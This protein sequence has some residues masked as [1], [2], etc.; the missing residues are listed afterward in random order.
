M[1]L[2]PA[3]CLAALLGV[4][5]APAAATAQTSSS[6]GGDVG[7][8]CWEKLPTVGFIACFDSASVLNTFGFLP[9]GSLGIPGFYQV[10]S[11]WCRVNGQFRWVS[12]DEALSCHRHLLEACFGTPAC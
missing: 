1:R 2:L 3:L 8:P 11:S 12:P 7:C 6:S 10:I 5:L 4:A 9:Y